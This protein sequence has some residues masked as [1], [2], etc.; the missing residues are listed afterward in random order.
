MKVIWDGGGDPPP[1][2][3]VDSSRK[4]YEW[5]DVVKKESGD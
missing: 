5:D 3:V 4:R 2:Y 1:K